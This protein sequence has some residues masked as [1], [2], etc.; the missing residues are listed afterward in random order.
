MFEQ[1]ARST[2]LSC[3]FGSAIALPHVLALKC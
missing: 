1:L 2:P 3:K